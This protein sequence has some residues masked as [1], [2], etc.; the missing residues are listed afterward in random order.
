MSNE[1]TQCPNS[2]EIAST[3]HSIISAIQESASV[4]LC[5][6]VTVTLQFSSEDEVGV[7]P[8]ASNTSRSHRIAHSTR[9]YL[10]SLRR[11]VRKRDKV[12]L[13]NS[14]FYF[15]LL[16][17]NIEGARIV[18]TRLWDAL[19]WEVHNALEANVVRPSFMKI[20][21][22][23][24][25]ESNADA[26]IAAASEPCYSFDTQPEKEMYWTDT[27]QDNNEAILDTEVISL[28]NELT[29]LAHKLGIPYLSLLPRKKPEQIQRLVT[30]KLARELQCYPLG[31]ERGTLT[32][33]LSNPQDSSILSRLQQETGLRI[34]PVLTH[35]QELQTALNLLV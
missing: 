9:Y 14:T 6:L 32:V 26:C 10:Q 7:Q 30:L 33:A 24:Y 18:E 17:A 31:R 8:T 22:A 25:A 2:Y 20:G 11:L 35:P 34:F 29:T 13:L 1:T 12:F 15:V 5:A 19:L 27:L 28:E 16:D 23:A 4:Q 21:H 3:L